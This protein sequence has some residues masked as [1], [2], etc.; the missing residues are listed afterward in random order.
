MA[1]PR[2][3]SRISKRARYDADYNPFNPPVDN[4]LGQRLLNDG[5]NEHGHEQ[6]QVLNTIESSTALR[7]T[8]E[9]PSIQS[10]LEETKRLVKVFDVID[11]SMTETREKL[12]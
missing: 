4:E 2:T 7:T 9:E 8:E 5:E 1:E 10:E 3:P 6:Q 11:L 12:K